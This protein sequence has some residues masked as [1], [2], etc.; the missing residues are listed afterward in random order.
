MQLG[1]NKETLKCQHTN[2]SDGISPVHCPFK[3]SHKSMQNLEISM[4]V[5]SIAYLNGPSH[6]LL[7]IDFEIGQKI[8]FSYF[9]LFKGHSAIF[10]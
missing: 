7:F 2:Y 4:Q 5:C 10:I 6:N 9:P 3:I 8:D 1:E